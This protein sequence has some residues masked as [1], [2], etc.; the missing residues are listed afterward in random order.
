MYS[1]AYDADAGTVADQRTLI[2][3]MTNSGHV[4]RT[5]L[6]SRKHPG[7][8]LVSRGS[9][10]N[11]DALAA[12]E[13]SGISQLRAFN[14]SAM[15]DGSGPLDYPSQGVLVGWGLRNSVGVAEHPATGGVYSV[16]NSADQIERLGI[17]IHQNNP[18]E[19]LN[20]HGILDGAAPPR[21]ANYGYPHCFALWSA[22]DDVPQRGNM[23]VGS[24][25]ALLGSS[26]DDDGDDETIDDAACAR[27]FVAPRLTF[28][29]HTAPL[30]IKFTA[31]GDAAYVTF[32]GSWNRDEPI[33]YRLSV[34][35]FDAAKGEPAEPADSTAAAVDVLTNQDTSQCPR[36]CFRPVGLAFDPAG[37]LFMTSDST[38]EI[39][40]LQRESGAAGD[41]SDPT[42]PNNGGSGLGESGNENA[43]PGRAARLPGGREWLLV[44]SIV[45]STVLAGAGQVIFE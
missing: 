31:G 16:E 5:L 40:V 38:G 39:Y 35:S 29:A 18:G 30:D 26:D 22:A 19:E 11:M 42:A 1:W 21:G 13:S 44:A 3:N 37:R 41:D 25:F 2:Q 45:A 27:D 8:L 32:H 7:T 34:V 20:F 9:S 23:T 10:E 43:A 12:D 28:Q 33:G 24:Q 4:T 6:L 36:A 14:L 17:D 15:D